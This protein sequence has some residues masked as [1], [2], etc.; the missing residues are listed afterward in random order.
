MNFFD[1]C[2]YHQQSMQGLKSLMKFGKSM[3]T[4]DRVK[5]GKST[6]SLSFGLEAAPR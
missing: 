2:G 4:D 5:G 3:Q 1:G 6:E